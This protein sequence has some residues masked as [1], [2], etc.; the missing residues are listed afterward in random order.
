MNKGNLFVIVYL[1]SMVIGIIIGISIAEEKSDKPAVSNTSHSDVTMVLNQL[2]A[3]NCDDTGHLVM[4]RVYT[5]PEDPEPL[6]AELRI[7]HNLTFS[8]DETETVIDYGYKQDHQVIVCQPM[9]YEITVTRSID[10]ITGNVTDINHTFYAY[11]IGDNY[12]LFLT[13][14]TVG[15]CHG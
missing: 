14:N 2:P 10:P 5:S 13:N 1:L 12:K 9:K 6:W 7:E 15:C 3:S 4:I 8:G 11:L